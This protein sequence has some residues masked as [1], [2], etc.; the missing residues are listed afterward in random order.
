MKFLVPQAGGFGLSDR[1]GKPPDGGKTNEERGG[2]MRRLLLVIPISAIVIVGLTWFKLTRT[3]SQA[4]VAAVAGAIRPAPL[5]QLYDEHSQ[6][7]RLAR[8]IGRHKLLVVFYDGTRGPDRS[9]L[10]Q[11][12]KRNYATIHDSGLIVLA[13]GASRPAENRAGIERDGPFP[14]PLLSD[15]F[16][17]EAHRSWGAFDA[18]TNKPREAVFVV[19]RAGMIRYGHLGPGDPGTPEDWA[20]ELREVR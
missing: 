17:Y 10:L 16:D 19:D 5:F 11:S 8:Y 18:A 3:Y 12:V 6:I 14:F 4:P 7:V 15:I 2:F 13:I 20:R 1:D 9:E